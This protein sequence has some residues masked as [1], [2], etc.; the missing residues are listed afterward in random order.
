[1]AERQHRWRCARASAEN[2]ATIDPST[3]PG[4]RRDDADLVVQIITDQD[5]QSQRPVDDPALVHAF[6]GSS[7][8]LAIITA[9]P[10]PRLD[11][12]AELLVEQTQTHY[13]PVIDISRAD[14]FAL[15]A[16]QLE[17]ALPSVWFG[18]PCFEGVGLPLECAFSDITNGFDPQ[19]SQWLSKQRS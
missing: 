6:S 4:F 7:N 1:L 8:L 13:A 11:Q 18:D 15:S 3:N 10:A 5:D 2:F 12:L 9:E 17:S 16:E 19:R 14:A